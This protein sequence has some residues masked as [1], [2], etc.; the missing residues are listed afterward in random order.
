MSRETPERLRQ[1]T[2]ELLLTKGE[3]GITLRDITETAGANV[4]AVAY[5]FKSKDSLIA[6]VFS[7]AIDEVTQLQTKRVLELPK[8]H[9]LRQLIEVWLHPLLSSAG[10]NDREAKLW[11]IIQRGAAEKAPGLIVNMSRADNPVEKTLIPLFASHLSHLSKEELL[12][13]HNAIIGGLAG[14][15]SSPVGMALAK[16]TAGSKSREFMISWIIG[17][18]TGPATDL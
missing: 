10:P 13:R 14:L 12:F 2:E 11:R 9:T 15:V 18:L 8:D 16:E 17:S 7:E 5:H 6:L 3:A 1:A 4:A